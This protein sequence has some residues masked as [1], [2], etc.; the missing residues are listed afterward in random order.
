MT[1]EL[2][3]GY[4]IDSFYDRNTKSYITTLRDNES[5]QIG[6]ASYSGNMTDRDAD[7]QAI[8][9]KFF[10]EYLPAIK[11]GEDIT[12]YIQTDEED[13]PEPV[14]VH[15]D[16]EDF[17][18]DS[19][20]EDSL[21]EDEFSFEESLKSKVEETKR[22]TKKAKLP[23]LSTLSPIMP[24]G[25]AGIDTFNSGVGLSEEWLDR[26]ELVYRLKRMGYHN[27]NFDRHSD[28][29]LYNIYKKN[30]ASLEKKARERAERNRN[31]QAYDR[32]REKLSSVK[33]DADSDTYSDGS[34][35]KDGIEFESEDAAR[36]Y[37]EESMRRDDWNVYTIEDIL[38]NA[39]K[40]AGF[41]LRDDDIDISRHDNWCIVEIRFIDPWLF[42][43]INKPAIKKAFKKELGLS[44]VEQSSYTERGWGNSDYGKT[45]RFDLYMNAPEEQKMNEDYKVGRKIAR[46]R[47]VGHRVS[48][49][50]LSKKAQEVLDDNGILEI[51]DG[52]QISD[53]GP[54]TAKKVS[55]ILN[56]N[57]I[58]T[59]VIERS[60]GLY[61][62]YLRE[63]MDNKFYLNDLHEAWDI[64]EVSLYDEYGDDPESLRIEEVEPGYYTVFSHDG[65]STYYF[66]DSKEDCVDWC[67]DNHEK[68]FFYESVHNKSKQM[69]TEGVKRKS[70]KINHNFKTLTEGLKYFDRKAFEENC[71][72]PELEL[73]YEGIKNNLDANDIK[74][75]GS[76]IQKANNA[77]EITT[78]LKGL[79]SEDLDSEDVFDIH[80]YY[81]LAENI[82]NYA[83]KNYNVWNSDI[84]DVE[85]LGD[86]IEIKFFVK[87]D[88]KHDH[89][90]F[91][92]AVKEYLEQNNLVAEFPEIVTF[93]IYE[94][95]ISD[96]EEYDSDFYPSVHILNLAI[97]DATN[98]LPFMNE[99]IKRYSDVVPYEKRKYWYFTTH[100]V[101]PGTIPKDLNVL[102]IKEGQNKKGT[103]GDFVCLDGVLNTSELQKYDMK[104]EAPKDANL[105]E[106]RKPKHVDSAFGYK[107][108]KAQKSG[109]LTP[110]N[111]EEWEIEYNDGRKPNPAF[112]TRELMNFYYMRPDYFDESLTESYIEEWWGQTDEDPHDLVQYGLKVTEVKNDGDE[113]LY[114]FEGRK[115][116]I[117]RAMDDGYFA[118]FDY[119]ED[120]G[121]SKD[122]EKSYEGLVEELLKR[123]RTVGFELDDSVSNPIKKNVISGRHIQ[124]INPNLIFPLEEAE[125]DRKY[126]TTLMWDD[127]KETTEVLENF[128]DEY[129]SIITFDFGPNND[130]IITGGIDIR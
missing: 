127:L 95:E 102:D 110:D 34:Y 9:E 109:E 67:E 71:E 60:G 52:S 11:N 20:S 65:N 105:T 4:Y 22:K 82:L 98:E 101:G 116:D 64:E 12:Q 94:E 10:Q 36:D 66:G 81:D 124:V 46:D 85:K 39:W 31:K 68:Y 118:S 69:L 99:E 117:E 1:K 2:K 57:G 112:N 6:D 53:L 73:L 61:T 78:Y 55:I 51:V 43:Q 59:E 125:G 103:W 87:G 49:S 108:F 27:Y 77:D 107:V 40:D 50:P 23:A 16:D 74:K 91:D 119:E 88:W 58:D 28:A 37:F 33:Y 122:L 113:T 123:L 48:Q 120:A 47:L 8:K 17:D 100:G 25:A 76:F 96:G 75:L 128:K 121:H 130:E 84:Y 92:Y 3:K 126:A 41:R 86:E 44:K 24:D 19:Y 72:M 5:N 62:I 104:E 15:D 14:M 18:W 30:K 89:L 115:T 90:R 26:D 83:N 114:R 93:N 79:L 70:S 63:S 45:L 80:K 13:F 97:A 21:D 129:D 29:S 32:N 54:K 7:V 106:A 42:K 35:Y 56:N 111:I 38:K